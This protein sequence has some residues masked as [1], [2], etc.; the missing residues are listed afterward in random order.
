M[1][2]RARK[3]TSVFIAAMLIAAFVPCAA[4]ADKVV[5]QELETGKLD[6]RINDQPFATYNYGADLPKPF[7]LPVRSAAGI[8]I[9]RELGDASDSDHPHHTGMW[10]SVDEVNGIQFWAEKGPI[11]NESLKILSSGDATAAWSVN[12]QWTHPDSGVIQLTE[13]A[14]ITVHANRLLVYDMTL[15]ASSVDVSIEDTKEG[16]FGFRVAPSMKEKN[17]G[18]VI[19]SDGTETTANC[20]GK[21]FP[22]IDYF[23]TVDGKTVGVAIMD[24]PKNFRPSR[25]HVRDYGLFSISPF[26]EKAYTNGANE[27]APVHLKT[28]ESL[29]L[30][31]AMFFHDGDTKSANV[32]G[33]YEQFVKTS[34][35]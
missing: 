18:S 2:G 12:N 26:G 30:R 21:P 20:W 29:R 31:Y 14:T 13:A 3:L 1:P 9:N 17:G 7:L 16:L 5:L 6:L 15:T 28:G 27:A 23:G 33:A 34:G 25:Y 24:H 11:R 19:A 10:N 22:W 32:A 4:A 35:D 8:V